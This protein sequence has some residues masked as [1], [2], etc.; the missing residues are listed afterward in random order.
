MATENRIRNEENRVRGVHT[1]HTSQSHSTD[2]DGRSITGLIKELRDET[3]TL[4]R[5]EVA[6]AKTEM[7]E[8]LSRLT[9]NVTYLAVGGGIAFAG[10]IIL[11]MA[12]AAGTYV[13]LLAAGLSHMTS[14]WLA[15]LIVGG[16]VAVLGYAFVQKGLST[17]R[18]ESLVPQRTK[19]SLEHD[20]Q[21]LKEKVQ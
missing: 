3:T 19:E 20:K 1:H 10:L 5:Q 15:P 21:W 13:A 11:L 14:G 12:A 17:L 16:I 7:S 6:L 8:K 18:H 4:M 9:R 2:S